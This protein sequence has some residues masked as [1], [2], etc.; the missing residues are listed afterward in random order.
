MSE[1]ED[2]PVDISVSP[3]KVYQPCPECGSDKWMHEMGGSIELRHFRG[4]T[5]WHSYFDGGDAVD[6]P[7]VFRASEKGSAK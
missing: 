2:A 7:G 5:Q 3:I 1:D 6:N 4:C